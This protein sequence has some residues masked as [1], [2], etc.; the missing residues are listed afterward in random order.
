MF[1]GI[2]WIKLLIELGAVQEFI[3]VKIFYVLKA[4]RSKR[5]N[6]KSFFG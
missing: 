3:R 6:F 1:G 4:S 5:L 2:L